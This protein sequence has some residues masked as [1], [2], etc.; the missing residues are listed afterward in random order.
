M[1]PSS[2]NFFAVMPVSCHSWRADASFS[3]RLRDPGPKAR[4]KPAQGK[5]GTRAALGTRVKSD[6]SPERAEQF[7]APLQGF[8][9]I[10][11]SYRGRR[12]EGRG[13]ALGLLASER[14]PASR[15]KVN[16]AD[17]LS[18]IGVQHLYTELVTLRLSFGLARI[19]REWPYPRYR[20]RLPSIHRP[21]NPI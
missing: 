9:Q 12:R 4:H 16:R 14:W 15:F 13:F 17:E 2:Q 21:T 7:L 1:S 18:A 8:V 20:S 6:E 10:A 5:R 3:K 11:D 19:P